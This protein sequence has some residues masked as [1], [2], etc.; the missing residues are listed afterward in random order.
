LAEAVIFAMIASY[1][2]SRTLVPTLAMY[3]MK[4]HGAGANHDA[5]NRFAFFGWF[6]RFHQRFNREFEKFR[7]AYRDLL[8]LGLRN[9]GKL[10]TL[11]LGFA[12]ASSL[13]YPFLGQNF[14]PSVD[15]GQFEM[16]VRTRAGTRIEETARTVD[17][18]EQTI[19]QIIP[20]NQV[21]MI[22]DN[23]GIPYS[24]INLSYNT[25]G[26][27]SS[28]DCDI[29]VAL[30][31]N[32]DPTD[33]FVEA[34]RARMHHDFPD[35]GVWFPPADIVSQTLNFGL[36][37][38]IDIQITGANLAANSKFA[39]RLMEQIRH[40][41]G[42]VDFRIQEP[43]DELQL[44]VTI[45]RTLASIVGINAQAVTQSVLSALSGSNRSLQTSGSIRAIESAIR[46]TPKHRS[47]ICILWM[48]C[49]TFPFLGLV[50]D[51]L[52][53]WPMSPRFRARPP[54][55][56]RI[57][58]ISDRSSIFTEGPAVKTW[59][60]CQTKYRSWSML[61]EKICPE[62]VLLVSADR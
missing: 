49:E 58:I 40:V 61:P 5:R 11:V 9:A 8:S 57:T 39:N 32:H 24:G 36:P 20:A 15:T 2:L 50:R 47:M 29:L 48:T 34:I 54:L 28:A 18:I 51:R 12:A 10:V 16:H 43:N 6:S 52:R 60:M 42:A 55:R 25:T 14:F 13:L 53:L 7:E 33:N 1:I 30:K 59:D 62:V 41:P 22:V 37:A 21:Q 4:A 3:W 44:N 56:L 45:D 35:V 31:E 23:M 27:M 26:T 38:P 19:R 17:Q 46:S